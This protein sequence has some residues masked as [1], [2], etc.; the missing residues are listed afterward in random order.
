MASSRWSGEHCDLSLFLRVPAV[1]GQHAVPRTHEPAQQ[2]SPSLDA[3]GVPTVQSW[4]S[5]SHDLLLG[6]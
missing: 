3:P 1:D 2:R 6:Y 4:F 5:T